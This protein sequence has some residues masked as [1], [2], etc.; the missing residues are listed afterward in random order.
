MEEPVTTIDKRYSDASAVPATWEATRRQL[1]TAELCWLVTVR[2][3]GRPHA[4]PVVTVWVDDSLH[5]TT[6]DDEQKG[7]NLRSG[8]KVLLQTG[9]LDWQ[10]GTDVVVEGR[11]TLATDEAL[12]ARVAAAW[13]GRWDGRWGFELHDGS[14]RHSAGFP[15]LTYSVSP[16]KVFAFAEGTFGQTVHRFPAA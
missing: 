13:P 6:G 15:V 14:L 12:L 8:D 10:G 1:E 2:S 4:T 16:D 9:R 5:F 11:A 3:D 7:V